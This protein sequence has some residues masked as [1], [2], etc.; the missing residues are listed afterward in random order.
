MKTNRRLNLLAAALVGALTFATTFALA[1]DSPKST[2]VRETAKEAF[3]YGFPI[4]EGYK[5]FTSRP[6]I[7]TA[8]I[9]KRRSTTS[10][11]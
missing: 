10:A 9:S 3:I 8:L 6:L 5:R 1:D 7:Q 4:V 2:E 11:T